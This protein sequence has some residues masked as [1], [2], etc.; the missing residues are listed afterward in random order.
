MKWVDKLD[1]FFPFFGSFEFERK[2]SGKS[3]AKN[4][5]RGLKR[6]MPG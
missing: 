4:E 1:N 5:V 3:R 6:K 2:F